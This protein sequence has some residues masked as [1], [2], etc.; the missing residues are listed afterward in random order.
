MRIITM[1][2]AGCLLLAAVPAFAHHSL[3]AEFDR[4]KPISITGKVTKIEWMNPHIW[5]YLDAKDA[6]GKVVKWQFEGGPPNALRRGG[7]SRE[8]LKEGDTAT[9]TGVMAKIDAIAGKDTAHT[10]HAEQVTLPGGKRV[11]AGNADPSEK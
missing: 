10:A 4:N 2:V 9:F 8:S 11:F 3:D 1:L 7:W 5:V 6:S